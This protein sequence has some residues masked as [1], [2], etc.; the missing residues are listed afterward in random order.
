MLTPGGKVFEYFLK[1]NQFKSE[2]FSEKGL[3]SHN[4]DNCVA[5]RIGRDTFILAVAD[6]MGGKAGGELASRLAISSV[7]EYLDTEFKDTRKEKNLKVILE[8]SFL[9]AQNAIA[10]HN[11]SHPDLRGMGTTL[12][13]LLI[14]HNRYVWGNL[15]DSRI[16]MLTEGKLNLITEDH[17]YL[18]DFIIKQK[19]ELPQSIINQ[20][21]NVVTKIID[22][23]VDKPDVFPSDKE[24]NELKQGDL[25]LLCSDGLIVDKM[26]DLTRIFKEIIGSNANLKDIS[27][28][29]VEWALENGSDDNISV[30]LGL[31]GHMKKILPDEEYKTIRIVPDEQKRI[32]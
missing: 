31:S 8:K 21:K 1:M 23:G 12:T 6:G 16:Y 7:I 32:D 10:D 4:E 29:L 15:G 5:H 11:A 18:R 2:V 3:R 13:A 30:V 17:T 25:F 19:K 9:V 24:W 20:Y 26:G 22:G 28:K 27:K 14:D